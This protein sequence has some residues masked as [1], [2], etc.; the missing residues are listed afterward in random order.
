MNRIHFFLRWQAFWILLF[1][2]IQLSDAHNVPTDQ[3]LYPLKA[4]HFHQ[5]EIAPDDD[6][7]PLL[8]LITKGLQW[9]PL[10]HNDR[11]KS[12]TLYS[13][14][15]T[16]NILNKQ[17]REPKQKDQIRALFSQTLQAISGFDGTNVKAVL[18]SKTAAIA[19]QPND[20]EL[21]RALLTPIEQVASSIDDPVVKALALSELAQSAAA[22]GDLKTARTLFTQ[23]RLV[24]SDTIT[25]TL[26]RYRLYQLQSTFSPSAQPRTP[27]QDSVWLAQTLQQLKEL[28]DEGIQTNALA[29][30]SQK[31]TQISNKTQAQQIQDQLFR[32]THAIQPE[33]I[34]ARLLEILA[35]ATLVLTDPVARRNRLI[36]LKQEAQ[37][38]TDKADQRQALPSI[39]GA[40]MQ[41]GERL[42]KEGELMEM[43][44]G[45]NRQ[46]GNPFQALANIN[47]QSPASLR[48]QVITQLVG[49]MALVAAQIGDQSLAS[50]LTQQTLQA[51]Y[52]IQMASEFLSNLVTSTAKA[53]AQASDKL[54]AQNLLLQANQLVQNID[55]VKTQARSLSNL[56]CWAA[57]TGEFSTARTHL[58]Q[59]LQ[60][61]IQGSGTVPG[62]VG[63]IFS[64]AGATVTTALQVSDTTKAR[65]W[66]NQ[67]V[68]VVDSLPDG[69]AK[70]QAYGGILRSLHAWSIQQRRPLNAEQTYALLTRSLLATKAINQAQGKLYVLTTLIGA[71]E[72]LSPVHR[73]PLITQL[74]LAVNSLQEPEKGRGLGEIIRLL[75]TL[76]KASILVGNERQAQDLF[77]QAQQLWTGILEAAPKSMVAYALLEKKAQAT[78]LIKNPVAFPHWIMQFRATAKT[79]DLFVNTNQSLGILVKAMTDQARQTSNP[80]MTRALVTQ[81]I[82]IT[83][84]LSTPSAKAIPLRSILQAGIGV[85]GRDQF[86]A[87]FTQ[88]LQGIKAGEKNSQ[89]RELIALGRVIAQRKP[90]S[91]AQGLLDPILEEVKH[92]DNPGVKKYMLSGLV[93]V[94]PRDDRIEPAK[95]LWQQVMA[96]ANTLDDAAAQE[97][98]LKTLKEIQPIAELMSSKEQV[99]SLQAQQKALEAAR[100]SVRVDVL[101]TVAE[102]MTYWHAL[103]QATLVLNQVIPLHKVQVVNGM[104]TGWLKQQQPKRP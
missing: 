98:T 8:D 35:Q 2:V 62:T 99:P 20:V 96:L 24:A 39:Y 56:A 5:P 49:T 37:S 71:V 15:Q 63:F 76:A 22:V 82:K 27:L 59:S 33:R 9:M 78:A 97:Q 3:R 93:T 48:L 66:L 43:L 46:G 31:I 28:N 87:L 100:P 65:T 40:S 11:V 89:A 67:V 84:E 16:L 19:I 38:L 80:E 17:A 41:S 102:S 44:T 34:K 74:L 10:S 101:G 83:S 92:T 52:G 69:D 45:G 75:G 81:A 88:A 30:F 14:A 58:K 104:L 90:I 4:D 68:S 60:Q 1:S 32:A 13:I 70:A 64:T 54:I 95:V 36:Q 51:S 79:V 91:E 77:S 103:D 72:D 23:T 7:Q 21:S 55:E 57:Q 53:A 18:L 50:Q 6:L 42:F 29:R 86:K 26:T 61:P 73:Q 25:Q 85:L 94:D 47:G 12:E